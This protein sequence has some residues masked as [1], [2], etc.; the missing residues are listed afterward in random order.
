MHIIFP[1]DDFTFS[2]DVHVSGNAHS[3]DKESCGS[4]TEPCA[5][6]GF[7]VKIADDSDTVLLD[8]SYDYPHQGSL[9]I[10]KHL[11]I[12][13]Y[14][15][16]NHGNDTDPDM[17]ANITFHS[18]DYPFF[19][20][21][22]LFEISKNLSVANLMIVVRESCYSYNSIFLLPEA[23]LPYYNINVTGCTFHSKKDLARYTDSSDIISALSTNVSAT[24]TVLIDSSN[25]FVNINFGNIYVSQIANIDKPVIVIK[26]R[27]TTV[28]ESTFL[29]RANSLFVE[30]CH[31]INTNFQFMPILNGGAYWFFRNSFTESSLL[32]LYQGLNFPDPVT[33]IAIKQ[34]NFTATV[35][36]NRDFLFPNLMNAQ[37]QITTESVRSTAFGLVVDIDNCI[38]R[39][40]SHGA[41]YL[42]TIASTVLI[43][44][45]KFLSNT[46]A[47]RYQIYQEMN[48]RAG[49]LTVTGS[50]KV[51]IANCKFWNNSASTNQ[52]GSLKV[53]RHPFLSTV[54]T[55]ENNEIETGIHANTRENTVALISP[56]GSPQVSD[57]SISNTTIKC[58]RDE[59][60][61]FRKIRDVHHFAVICITCDSLSYNAIYRAQLFLKKPG[62]ID[63]YNA[64]CYPCPYQASCMQ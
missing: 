60:M 43:R 18:C 33:R 3:S 51:H 16:E 35:L 26:L 40:A 4:M 36:E 63:F 1:L 2:A 7:A 62:E 61:F 56:V 64:K 42:N 24:V 27:N 34:N 21:I 59:T 20:V 49:G 31:F 48:N 44:N 23:D 13:S 28:H 15:Y 46:A 6:I 9:S 50:Q 47:P 12:T 39:N 53:V 58:Q 17:M 29:V 10:G 8:R 5:T 45:T 41:L 14:D 38:F 25:I 55:L 37:L 32:A 57:V 19:K 30:D 52:V 22:G 54:V 11:R